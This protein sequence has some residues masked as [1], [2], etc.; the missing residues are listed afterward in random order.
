METKNTINEK[1]KLVYG[2]PGAR[3]IVEV[4]TIQTEDSIKQSDAMIFVNA[5]KDACSMASVNS[6]HKIL[7]VEGGTE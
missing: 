1:T 6:L 4:Q 5:V 7:S 2:S 3:I